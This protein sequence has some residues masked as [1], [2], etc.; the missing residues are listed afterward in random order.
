MALEGRSAVGGGEA[1]HS[2]RREVGLHGPQ[3]R[4]SGASKASCSR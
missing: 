1:E 4:W 2:G 3:G